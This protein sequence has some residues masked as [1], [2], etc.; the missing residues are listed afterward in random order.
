MS[1]PA[2]Q[3]QLEFACAA[4]GRTVLA[5]RRVA[6]PYHVTTPIAGRDDAVLVVQSA[7]G[8]FYGDE[9]LGQCVTAGANARVELRFPSAAVVNAARGLAGARQEV[10]LRLE[11][12]ATLRYGQRPLVLLPGARVRQTM[13][14]QVGAGAY[15]LLSEGVT[16]HAPVGDP[17]TPPTGDPTTP[18]ADDPTGRR[19]DNRLQIA[20]A[21]GRA[22]AIDRF[23]LD[24]ATIAAACPGVAGRWRAFGTLWCVAPGRTGWRDRLHQDVRTRAA[25]D[26]GTA[27]AASP[28]AGDAGLM[29]R[30]A[31]LDGGGLA[32]ALEALAAL[33]TALLAAG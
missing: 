26:P 13:D 9:R 24:D 29:V 33:A 25:A 30:L 23:V 7:S 32:A 10:R 19:F 21:Q 6:Y 14:V 1:D 5:R 28:F 20:D 22:L 11:E 12:G 8:G 27:M 17:T 18:L 2:A 4:G 31:A 3:L 16:V 15:L